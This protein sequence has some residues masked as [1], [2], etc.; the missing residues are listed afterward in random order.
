M[1]YTVVTWSLIIWL[2]IITSLR[3]S[4]PLYAFAGLI[5]I[6]YIPLYMPLL[7]TDLDLPTPQVLESISSPPPLSLTMVTHLL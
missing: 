5:I 6:L 7:K 4:I 1:N 3:M 2:I